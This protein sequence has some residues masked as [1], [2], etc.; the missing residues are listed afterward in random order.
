[1]DARSNVLRFD[2]GDGA[3]TVIA[4]GDS[5]VQMRS[6]AP[7]YASVSQYGELTIGYAG[8]ADRMSIFNLENARSLS[9]SHGGQ[10]LSV[11]GRV[12]TNTYSTIDLIG[13][14]GSKYIK[15]TAIDG[16]QQTDYFSVDGTH[17]L[18]ITKGELGYRYSINTGGE[19]VKQ[20]WNNAGTY[21]QYSAPANSYGPIETAYL[22]S[23]ATFNH[24]LQ[25]GGDAYYLNYS[26]G[27][28]EW[29]VTSDYYKVFYGKS[30]AAGNIWQYT[31]DYSGNQS[32]SYNAYGYASNIDLHAD[33]SAQQFDWS[34]TQG[35][36]AVLQWDTNGKLTMWGSGPHNGW[37]WD[38]RD[39]STLN[40]PEPT[41]PTIDLS[42]DFLDL[43]QNF[44]K[45]L[46]APNSK[47]LLAAA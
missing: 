5:V 40:I 26:S 37:P 7:V 8:T 13:T 25:S 15:T 17:S 4:A 28:R 6:N 44:A 12:D 36:D 46:Q 30:D 38:Y 39:T 31:L 16:T 29:Y 9:V 20:A 10:S 41:I 11:F 24:Y 19:Y 33:G 27:A 23:G 42:T 1:M 22:N 35:V 21:T 2:Q 32:Y 43:K 34:W 14:D 18:T 3:D 47:S 45:F